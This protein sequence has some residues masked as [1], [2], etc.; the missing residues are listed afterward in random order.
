[1]FKRYRL[2]NP[3]LKIIRSVLDLA[4]PKNISS[5]WRFGSLLGVCLITQILTGLFLAIYFAS[6]ITLAFDSAVYISRDVN[7]GWLIRAIHA[8]RAS[9]FFICLYVHTGRGLY[10]R[11]FHYIEVWSIG[12]TLLLLTIIT[13]F[14][15][16]VLPWGQI[17]YWAATVITN[18][19]SSVPY[20]GTDVVSW[21]WGG[22]SV[23]NATLVRFYAF[24]FLFPFLIAALSLIHILYLHQEGSSNPLGINSS[25]DT[26]KFHPYFTTKDLFGFFIIWLILGIIVLF[27]PNLLID[28][29]NFIPANPLVTPTHIQPEWYFLPIYAILRSIPNKLGGV[30]GL[31]M[32][33]AILY[34]L[35]L[36]IKPTF[37]S[38]A[39]N[40]IN[41]LVFWAIT[42]RFT[43]LIWIGSKPVETPYEGIGITFTV[44]YFFLFLILAYTRKLPNNILI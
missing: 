30:I 7:Y 23:S 27:S 24:H 33:I 37:R 3:V 6:D 18:L 35:P 43:I 32:S 31:I 1:M 16:Y 26:I 13:A 42:A 25:N 29:E 5:L 40:I 11:S 4:A 8:N 38:S 12:I 14:L 21:L 34:F 41:Q 44:I 15:G 36:Y 20:V 28:P 17:S 2:L 39:F 9:I 19:V 22:F 10:Y